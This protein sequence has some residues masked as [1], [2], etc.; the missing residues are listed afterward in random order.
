MKGHKLT[1]LTIK[2]IYTVMQS[3]MQKQ[4]LGRE[5]DDCPG[6]VTSWINPQKDV[7]IIVWTYRIFILNEGQV[8]R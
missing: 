7:S 4:N 2:F 5:P 8:S 1:I 6:Q 3:A